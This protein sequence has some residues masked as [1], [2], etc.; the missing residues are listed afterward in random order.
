[1]I[2]VDAEAAIQLPLSLSAVSRQ[3]LKLGIDIAQK[4]VAK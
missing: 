3:M 4:T 2:E 1:V